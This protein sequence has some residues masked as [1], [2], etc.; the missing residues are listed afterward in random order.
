MNFRTLNPFGRFPS[1]NGP[2]VRVK[3][4]FSFSWPL[5]LFLTCL[6][7]VLD[8]LSENVVENEVLEKLNG[9]QSENT[10]KKIK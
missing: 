1:G 9:G 7:P 3:A 6:E 10:K 4:D 5:I 8:S 2:T